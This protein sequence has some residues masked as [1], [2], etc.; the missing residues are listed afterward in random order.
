VEGLEAWVAFF[1]FAGL[2]LSGCRKNQSFS[3]VSSYFPWWSIAD[4]ATRW[5]CARWMW[6]YMRRRRF[7]IFWGETESEGSDWF[8][9]W[10]ANWQIGVTR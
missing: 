10:D 1:H 5:W 7:G 4:K 8:I 6:I 3:L 2:G 9:W